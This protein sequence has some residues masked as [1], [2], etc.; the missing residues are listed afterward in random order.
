MKKSVLSVLVLMISMAGMVSA[1]VCPISSTRC[2]YTVYDSN[3]D[4]CGTGTECAPYQYCWHSSCMRNY[5]CGQRVITERFPCNGD[6]A[7]YTWTDDCTS[8]TATGNGCCRSNSDCYDDS[9]GDVCAG[10]KCVYVE[11][12]CTAD[13]DCDAGE[14]CIDD[15]CVIPFCPDYTDCDADE[16]CI[17]GYCFISVPRVCIPYEEIVI[18]DFS[19]GTYDGWEFSDSMSGVSISGN[20]VVAKVDGTN[21]MLSKR[22]DMDPSYNHLKMDYK[23]Y[24]SGPTQ[25]EIFWKLT[26]DGRFLN[27]C[28][29]WTVNCDQRYSQVL[30][31][32]GSWQTL[33]L[34]IDGSIQNWGS[35]NGDIR[36][37]RIDFNFDRKSQVDGIVKFGKIRLYKGD[38]AD[39]FCGGSAPVPT[40]TPTPTPAPVLVASAISTSCVDSDGGINYTVKGG[41]K[42]S[43]DNEELFDYCTR[44]GNIVDN[45]TNDD[46]CGILERY[47]N[48]DK[49]RVSKYILRG[50]FDKECPNGCKDGACLKSDADADDD[51]DD[52]GNADDGDDADADDDAD[53]TGNTDDHDDDADYSPQ[54]TSETNDQ[55]CS[56]LGKRQNGEFCSGEGFVDQKK[57]NSYCEN[58]FEC[59]SDKCNSG[60]C[61]G[62]GFFGT[63]FGWFKFWN[64]F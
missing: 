25:L 53:D 20:N 24:A 12:E 17:E 40:P 15:K 36:E 46:S 8:G 11:P 44:D 23:G 48:A 22:I 14:E 64:W 34:K 2:G 54:E 35:Y 33:D 18:G 32:G 26:V 55:D 3:G 19:G 41:V 50:D 39:P 52:T 49:K 31:T 27:P 29:Y 38:P 9:D 37:I 63:I 62:D 60:K 56:P 59:E 13:T 6:T 47:C 10:G 43:N 7:P 61:A 21:P 57:K 45:C 42:D 5:E 51:A 1:D 30:N 4:S 28:P 58:Y 16:V